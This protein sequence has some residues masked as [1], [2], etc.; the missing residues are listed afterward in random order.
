MSSRLT[1]RE[2]ES[3]FNRGDILTEVYD[4]P[5]DNQICRLRS[6]ASILQI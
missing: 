4:A 6:L 1:Q 5:D 2:R 3:R